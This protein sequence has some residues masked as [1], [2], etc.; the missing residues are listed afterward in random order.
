MPPRDP[1]A[2]LPLVAKSRGSAAPEEAA[3]SAMAPAPE[4]E[5]PDL[6]AAQAR[7]ELVMAP[8]PTVMAAFLQRTAP[9]A[10]AIFPLAPRL[11]PA[12]PL[13]EEARATSSRCPASGQILQET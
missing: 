11:F 10:P 5:C 7:L 4:A 2:C 6:I 12:S 3:A 1:L 13:A 8:I 9:V